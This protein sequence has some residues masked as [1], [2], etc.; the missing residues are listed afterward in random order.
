MG[1][2]DTEHQLNTSETYGDW[3]DQ[4]VEDGYVI[5]KGVISQE[6]ADHYLN[7]MFEWLE[8]FP[9]GFKNNDPSTWGPQNLPAHIK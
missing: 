4:L 3:R 7:S 2:Y 5:I 9:Y 1:S 6:K 8:G